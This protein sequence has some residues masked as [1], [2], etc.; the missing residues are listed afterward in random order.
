LFCKLLPP[1]SF[2]PAGPREAPSECGVP[3]ARQHGEDSETA[4]QAG[5]HRWVVYSV[6]FGVRERQFSC[7]GLF[8]GSDYFLFLLLRLYTLVKLF[9][10]VT[11]Y[12][13]N[14]ILWWLLVGT[15][16]AVPCGCGL[17]CG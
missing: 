7:F 6:M 10:H 8:R 2:L 4:V 3:E 5:E 14:C 17:M 15:T 16:V 1:P 9:V 13:G 11:A 12:C